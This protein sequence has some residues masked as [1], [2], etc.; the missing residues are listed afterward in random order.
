MAKITKSVGDVLGDAQLLFAEK[1]GEY[2][3]IYVDAGEVLKGV[4]G[5]SMVP[6]TPAQLMIIIHIINKLMRYA[7][8]GGHVDSADD[9]VVY[10]AMLRSITKEDEDGSKD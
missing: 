2:G 8:A 4:L 9:L 3:N 10:A 1:N 5:N 6:V 7:R